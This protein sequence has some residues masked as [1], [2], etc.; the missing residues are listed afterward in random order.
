[1]HKLWNKASAFLIIT[2]VSLTVHFAFYGHPGSM[3]FD[4]VHFGKF[5]SSY[6][7][8]E[9]YFDIHPPLGKLLI[10]GFGS[11]FGVGTV[12]M[13]YQINAAFPDQVHLVLRFLPTLSGALI[14]LLIFGILLKFKVP[15]IAAFFGGLLACLDNG[16]L[17]Q[18]RS[19][20]LDGFL[21]S[22]S[23]G[24][25]LL[26][27]T[28]RE[29][30]T[31]PWLVA[32]GLLGGAALGIKWTGAAALA[33]PLIWEAS[34]AWKIRNKGAWLKLVQRGAILGAAAL[35]LYGVTFI[36]HFSLLTKTGPGDAFHTPAFQKTLAGNPY[37]T[38]PGLT[39]ASL[40]EKIVELN[41]RMYTANRD[42][43]ATH[44]YSSPWYTWPVMARP[45]F[46]W[47][48]ADER[49]YLLG[50]PVLWW[51]SLAAVGLLVM[52]LFAHKRRHETTTTVLLGA[53]ALNFL[54]FVFIGR[55]MF[56]YHYLPAL[57]FAILLSVYLLSQ[58]KRK[59]L[60]LSLATALALAAFVW[61]APLSY[62]L[63]LDAAGAQSR[64]WFDTWR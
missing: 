23:L 46:Y 19:I 35:V 24:S 6:S 49:I 14:P 3:V 54:P 61:V 32:C 10:A 21:I 58:T 25:F 64:Q 56:L 4:E 39:P 27:L 26:Y 29:H 37:S 17:V 12:E 52:G 22:F 48:N 59:V 45:I 18:T 42:L 63:S 1:M 43:T 57:T 55:V 38:D 41:L 11:L 34:D 15:L 16:L 47:S 20:F 62:G 31:W 30:R 36:V 40:T 60:W 8:G 28:Y 33:L 13:P 44:T 50:N 7:T 51:G 5:V 53:W 9:Y 2:V